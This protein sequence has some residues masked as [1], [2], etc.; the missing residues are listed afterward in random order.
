MKHWL[1]TL[2]A[3]AILASG[4]AFAADLGRAPPAPV[5]PPLPVFTWTG[6][7]VGGDIGG[8]WGG[9]NDSLHELVLDSFNVD[10]VLGGLHAG[11]DWQNNQLV[12]G[13]EADV[14]GSGIKGSRPTTGVTGSLALTNDWQS[15][16]RLRAGYALDRT[17]IYATGG[18]AFADDKETLTLPAYDGSQTQTL[19]G[20]T[21]GGGV[22][23]ALTNNW[24]GRVEVRYTDF[25]KAN[26]ALDNPPYLPFKAGFHETTALVGISYL[27]H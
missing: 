7:Y 26:Y 16:V 27:F 1:G 11:Y 12:L 15:S 8:G 18:I 3:A 17:L 13:I 25:G 23:Q 4:S 5:P 10:G 6:F 22:E 21:I 19:T 14:D 9:E 24:I 2:G 20:W